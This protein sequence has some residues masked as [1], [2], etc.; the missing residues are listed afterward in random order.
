MSFVTIFI[1]LFLILLLEVVFDGILEIILSWAWPLVLCGFLSLVFF[2][3]NYFKLS[4][5]FILIG[6]IIQV[7]IIV[8]KII[9]KKHNL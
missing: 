8:Q 3:N 7:F 2:Y 6:V 1:G 4:I 9:F 5:L